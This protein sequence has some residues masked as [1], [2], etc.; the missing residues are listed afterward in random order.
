MATPSPG[1]RQCHLRVCGIQQGMTKAEV[2]KIKARGIRPTFLKDN[3]GNSSLHYVYESWSEAE[4]T[5]SY[6]FSPNGKVCEMSGWKLDVPLF[7][8]HLEKGM[9]SASLEKA[10]GS[11]SHLEDGLWSY[12]DLQLEVWVEGN[13]ISFFRVGKTIEK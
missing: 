12:P 5:E 2:K 6:G 4:K 10:F 3:G 1:L 11:P 13:R 9:A 7:S 8:I